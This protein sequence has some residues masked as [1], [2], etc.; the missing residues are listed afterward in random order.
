[1]ISAPTR[2]RR[3]LLALA[4]GSFGIGMTE[5]VVMGLLPEIARELLPAAWASSQED[6]IAQAGWLITLYALG[7]VIGA[8]TIAASVAKY[9]R[10]RVMILLAAAL[11]LFNALTLVLPTFELVAASRLLAGLPH[12]AYFGIGALVAADVMGPGNR[13]KGVAF[14][15]TGLTVAN[16]VGVPVGTFLGQN[17]GWRWAFVLVVAIFA[18][19]TA[20]IA[21]T[22]PRRAGEP[23]RTLRAELGVF[24]IGQVWFA[25]GIGAIGFGGFFAVYTYVSPL[26]TE[27]AG[28]P[29]WVVP[30]TLVILGIGMTVGNLVG[31]HLADVDLIR[32]MF[33][34]LGLLAL[35]LLLLAL[36]SGWIVTVVI[37]VF[38]VAF[39]A[40]AVSPTIQ[41]RLMDV[42]GDNQSIAAAL[43]HSALN[44]GNAMGAALGGAVIA[45]GFGFAAPVW[46]G[47]LLA[48]AGLGIAALSVTLE[49]RH[50]RTPALV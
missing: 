9:P 32:A 24:R 43:N 23:S 28:S 31:G 13:A 25:L 35:S 14:V 19:A 27:A 46:V 37:F 20:A 29:A 2:P 4:V 6:A 10:H 34:L 33:G 50:A 40:S 30:I 3:A 45:A 38:A 47:F 16:V 1:M 18:A 48:L 7:V 49:R 8:P 17:L 22:V 41:T 36:T 15:L 21:V 42:A 39:A 44:T 26:V 5:F 11:T 12:G